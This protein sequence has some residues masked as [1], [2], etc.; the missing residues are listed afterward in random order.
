MRRKTRPP[1][2]TLVPPETPNPGTA[3]PTQ[4][5]LPAGT[6]GVRLVL[7]AADATAVEA[8]AAA[9]KARFGARFAVTARRRAGT[10]LRVTGSLQVS[11]DEALDAEA[12]EVEG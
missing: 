8:A 12:R 11:V 9:L 4:L 10:G 2:L 1:P 7:D 5:L 6:T 3:R